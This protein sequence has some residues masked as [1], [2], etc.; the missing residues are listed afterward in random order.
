MA[1]RAQATDGRGE[2]LHPGA[3]PSL[4]A[5]RDARCRGS[6]SRG[7]SRSPA[8]T[9]RSRLSELFRGRSQ[10]IVYH[11]MFHPDWN[12][13]CKSC[14]FWADNFDR[15]DRRISTRATFESRR[16]VACA[17]CAKLDSVQEHA[18]AGAS[19]GCPAARPAAST[20]D[21]GVNFTPAETENER[22][23]TTTYGTHPFRPSR[24]RARLE[25]L[26]QG[27]RPARSITP[28]ATYSRGLDMLNGA[29]H[30]LDLVPKGAPRKRSHLPDAVG[31]AARR[32]RD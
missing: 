27:R 32:V 22:T 14:S 1:R 10:L 9:A 2:S 7:L 4:S 12:A 24:R 26:R 13:A 15:S 31:A 25:R 3:R 29:Y 11:F 18:W 8:P 28:T 23:T 21:F 17:A 20:R 19:H 30:Y 16:G 6:E 5:E